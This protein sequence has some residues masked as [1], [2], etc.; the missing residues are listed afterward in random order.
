MTDKP[1]FDSRPT[2]TEWQSGQPRG[3][4]ILRPRKSR[5]FL[6]RHPWVLDSA[7]ASV[8]GNPVDGDVVDLYSEQGGF[9]RG[10]ST[11]SEATY[12]CDSTRGIKTRLWM[13]HSGNGV[14]PRRLVGGD[15]W[16]CWRGKPPRDW[17][18]ARRTD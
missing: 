16:G 18:S 11:T 8:T 10:G 14:W 13:H 9:I 6:A 4:V 2:S 15:D 5:P 3:Q 7:V 17:C 1:E 12:A